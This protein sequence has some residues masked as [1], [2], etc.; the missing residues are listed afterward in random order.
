MDMNAPFATTS[1]TRIRSLSGGT[2]ALRD[3]VVSLQD[4][5]HYPLGAM[6]LAA[7]YALHVGTSRCHA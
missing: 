5:G 3:L 6:F 1:I 4:Y 7:W 2:I